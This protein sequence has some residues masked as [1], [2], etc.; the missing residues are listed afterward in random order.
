MSDKCFSELP[1]KANELRKERDIWE[2]QRIRIGAVFG[3]DSRGVRIRM[4]R[5]S[6]SIGAVFGFATLDNEMPQRASRKSS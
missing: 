1:V 5:C 4:A 6:D 3:F 2:I